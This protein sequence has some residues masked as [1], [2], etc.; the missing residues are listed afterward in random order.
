M[1]CKEIMQT[2][3]M[4]LPPHKTVREAAELMQRHNIGFLPVCDDDKLVGTLTDRDIAVRIVGEGRSPDD[5]IGTIVARQIVA[6]L[7]EDDI[8]RAEE[9]MVAERKSRILC[10]DRDGKLCG[11]LS[12]AD[13][14]E[15]DRPSRAAAT[16][17]GV[18]RREVRTTH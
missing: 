14:V 15:H 1:Q 2:H 9:L 18:V 6:C 4:C 13:I 16:L 12:I 10:V 8:A 11:V 5:T 7:P 3:V 17:R